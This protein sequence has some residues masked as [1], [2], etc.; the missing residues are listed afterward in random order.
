MHNRM[1]RLNSLFNFE[2][3]FASFF[4]LFYFMPLVVHRSLQ[5][6]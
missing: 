1:N 3:F 6:L 2:A 5:G 4:G